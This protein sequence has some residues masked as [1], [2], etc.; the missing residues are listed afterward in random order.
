M[1]SLITF[2]YFRPE[3]VT[4]VPFSLE[5][6]LLSLKFTWHRDSSD[7]DSFMCSCINKEQ[8]CNKW[9]KIM[10][11]TFLYQILSRP[12]WTGVSHWKHSSKR[13]RQEDCPYVHD[14][15]LYISP[16]LH[17]SCRA[18]RILWSREFGLVRYLL[19][20]CHLFASFL[21]QKS[22]CLAQPL[23]LY[24]GFYFIEYYTL[25]FLWPLHK[26]CEPSHAAIQW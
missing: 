9:K 17:Q 4:M 11:A 15:V 5:G 7:T 14:E 6:K 21:I 25:T 3:K 2:Q 1:C 24:N 13:N 23:L 18:A 22:L 26:V 10:S 19:R 20:A 16:W 12:H 8:T